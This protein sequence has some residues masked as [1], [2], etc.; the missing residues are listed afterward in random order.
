M[1]HEFFDDL[2]KDGKVEKRD[3]LQNQFFFGGLRGCLCPFV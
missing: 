1:P 3:H 2:V